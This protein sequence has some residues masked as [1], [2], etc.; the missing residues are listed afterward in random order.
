MNFPTLLELRRA[1]W[2]FQLSTDKTALL[3]DELENI[4]LCAVSDATVIQRKMDL[5]RTA[6]NERLI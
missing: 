4:K 2:L 3:L 6:S 5:C 1:C